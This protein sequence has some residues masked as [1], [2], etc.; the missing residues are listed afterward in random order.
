M[1]IYF[2]KSEFFVCF[3]LEFSETGIFTAMPAR[4]YTI[5]KMMVITESIIASLG[6]AEESA[7]GAAASSPQRRS[8]SF[9]E[10]TPFRRMMTSAVQYSAAFRFWSNSFLLHGAMRLYSA[11]KSCRE[12]LFLRAPSAAA[13]VKSGQYCCIQLVLLIWYCRRNTSMPGRYRQCM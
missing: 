8:R 1:S 5:Q 9:Q 10:R 4:F 3:N 11:A 7:G 13:A 6:K 12:S 2:P